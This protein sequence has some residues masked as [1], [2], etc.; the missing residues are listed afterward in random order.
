MV[1]KASNEWYFATGAM[2]WPFFPFAFLGDIFKLQ[3]GVELE[4]RD[5]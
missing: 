4:T 1:R 2:A 3:A 5:S